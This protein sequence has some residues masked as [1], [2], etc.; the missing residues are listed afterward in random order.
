VIGPILRA[1]WKLLQRQKKKTFW[2]LK[3]ASLEVKQGDVLD[4]HGRGLR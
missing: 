2:A 3:D 4:I 1:P